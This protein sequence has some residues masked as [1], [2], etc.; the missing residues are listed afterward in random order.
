MNIS[1]FSV[2]E[3]MRIETLV[4]FTD[5]II[6]LRGSIRKNAK[7]EPKSHSERQNY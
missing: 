3:D 5:W 2:P 4:V 7:S 1:K 6:L